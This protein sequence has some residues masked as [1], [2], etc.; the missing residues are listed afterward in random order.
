MLIWSRG[1]EYYKNKKK[2]E[3]F[4]IIYKIGKEIITFGNI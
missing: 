3:K 4:I 2:I 1:D